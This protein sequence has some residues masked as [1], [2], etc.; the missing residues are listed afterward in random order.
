MHALTL[1]A[2]HAVQLSQQLIDHPVSH[3]RAVVATLGGDGV[4][5]IEE[6]DARLGRR[7]KAYIEGGMR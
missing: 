1:Q 7:H 5:L 4:K 2:F 3:P 6:Q